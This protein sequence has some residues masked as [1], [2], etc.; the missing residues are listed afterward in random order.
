MSDSGTAYKSSIA[1]AIKDLVREFVG[2]VRGLV[3]LD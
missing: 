1:D 3:N 2:S